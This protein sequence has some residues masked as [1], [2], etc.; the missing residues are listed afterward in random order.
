MHCQ[1]LHTGPDGLRTLVAVLDTGDRTM[2]A[3]A[4]IARRERLTA[5]QFTAIGAFSEARLAYFDWETKEYQE[6]PVA[7][8]VEVASLV[9]DIGVDEAGE[10]A[11]HVHAVLGRRGGAALAGHLLD[12]TV[13]PTLEVVLTETPAHLH[14]RHDPATGLSLIRLPR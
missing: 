2:T 1:L 6:I 4:E 8:Q 9:G 11:L 10:P 7:E 5:A 14:R 3:L 13:R 12:G